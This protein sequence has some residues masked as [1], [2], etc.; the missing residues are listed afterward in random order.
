MPQIQGAV[1]L[2][3]HGFVQHNEE[4]QLHELGRR[5][6]RLRVELLGGLLVCVAALQRSLVPSLPMLAC[7]LLLVVVLGALKMRLHAL[8]DCEEVLL[9]DDGAWPGAHILLRASAREQTFAHT[10]VCVCVCARAH[11]SPHIVQCISPSRTLSSQ[12]MN[13]A[14]TCFSQAP[15]DTTVYIISLYGCARMKSVM[16]ASKM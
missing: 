4:D 3:R 2:A 11:C 15:T 8:V 16:H 7:A 5:M 13:R 10:C 6:W 12:Y 9:S 14:H 1:H